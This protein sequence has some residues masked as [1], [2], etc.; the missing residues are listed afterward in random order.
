[1]L[2]ARASRQHS[3]VADT[4]MHQKPK[5]R[6]ALTIKGF[7]VVSSITALESIDVAIAFY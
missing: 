3:A 4:A 5:A 7:L 1:M 2:D 6:L